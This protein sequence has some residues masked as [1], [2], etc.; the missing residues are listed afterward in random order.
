M[1]EYNAVERQI[2]DIVKSGHA[3]K[4]SELVEI[5]VNELKIN[6]E[7]AI[8]LLFELEDKEKIIFV[9]INNNIPDNLQ[10]Y[11][12]SSYAYWYWAVITVSLLSVFSVFFLPTD[13][14]NLNYVRYVFGSVYVLFLPGYC[15]YKIIYL[16][17]EV[18]TTKLILFS[19]GISVSLISILG[20]IMNYS[21]WGLHQAPL[22]IIEF[23]L[24]L[25]LSSIGI[26]RE[27]NYK[28]L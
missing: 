25:T 11:V 9:D 2:I 7:D 10:E 21:P 20:L 13:I 18:S 6:E 19:I 26:I 3:P 1:S 16:G 8:N 17:E 5:I 28:L 14:S 24:I 4:G 27:H 15:I 23:L 22:V 12:L